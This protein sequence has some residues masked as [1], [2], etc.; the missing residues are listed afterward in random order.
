MKNDTLRSISAVLAGAAVSIV[1]AVGTD[2]VMKRTGVFPASGGAMGDGL[3]VLATA[4]RTVYGVFGA[5]LTAR[6]APN[7]PM[8][9]ALILGAIGCAMGILG[10]VVSWNKMPEIGPRWYPIGLVPLGL[11][12]AWVGGKLRMMQRSGGVE[13]AR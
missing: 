1:L 5:Y 12:Q 9:H 8:M 2:E 6:L 10:V 3:F 11:A 7:R 13:S 4:Y